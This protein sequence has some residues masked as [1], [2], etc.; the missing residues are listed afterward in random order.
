[1]TKHWIWVVV[2]LLFGTLLAIGVVRFPDP[3]NPSGQRS[4]RGQ[5]AAASS[6][7]SPQSGRP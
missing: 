4:G 1:M 2:L 6:H 3:Q 5:A 7:T